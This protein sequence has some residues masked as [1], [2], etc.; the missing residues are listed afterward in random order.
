MYTFEY[1][2]KNEFEY[3]TNACQHYFDNT[4]SN[5]DHYILPKIIV[6]YIYLE[7]KEIKL[8]VACLHEYDIGI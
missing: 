2:V 8:I 1:F 5:Y 6:N 7:F 4:Y 3:Y